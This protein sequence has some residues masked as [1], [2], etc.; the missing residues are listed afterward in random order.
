MFAI[1][2]PL[3]KRILLVSIFW[4]LYVITAF[5]INV[6][7][8]WKE[9]HKIK[10]CSLRFDL[11]LLWV[12]LKEVHLDGKKEKKKKSGRLWIPD[13]FLIANL[14]CLK[15]I[16]KARK[17]R[18]GLPTLKSRTKARFTSCS[19]VLCRI[20]KHNPVLSP[21]CGYFWQFLAF[22]F[23]L[24]VPDVII[25]AL[26]S[27][28]KAWFTSCN[29]VLCRI[30]K[31]NLKRNKQKLITHLDYNKQRFREPNR[32]DPHF[33]KAQYANYIILPHYVFFKLVQY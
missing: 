8:T 3:E 33:I 10:K 13:T 14:A 5:F 31:H 28:T 9:L 20:F 29:F 24:L 11:N 12:P 17:K 6:K 23:T 4:T 21:I 15:R 26:N 7:I 16:D 1:K 19:F 27:R 32:A 2:Y 18:E 25:Q 22:L 30:F